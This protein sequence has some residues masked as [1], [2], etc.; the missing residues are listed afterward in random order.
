MD[1]HAPIHHAR[2]RGDG[3]WTWIWSSG[4]A[5]SSTVRERRR[6]SPTW[7]SSVT[8]WSP[9]SRR[10]SGRAHREI[11]ADGRVVTPGFVDIHTH[12]DA[13]LAWDPI[14]TSSCWH[15]VTSVV[16]G[17]C[18][19][20][21]APCR[22]EDR[23][24]LAELMESVEDIPRDAI[25]GGLPWD[26]VTYGEY[27]GSM[28]RLPKGPNVGGMVGHCAVRHH[29][30]GEREPGRHAR[31]RGR[32][33]GDG[34][35]GRRGHGRR[36]ARVL[37]LADAAPHRPRR[38]SGPRHVGHA[39]G[40]LRLRRRAR[41][42]RAGRLRDRLP[43]RRARRRGPGRHPGRDGV[44]GRGVPPLG[45]PGHLRAGPVGPPARALPPDRRLRQGAERARRVRAPADDGAGRR[46]AVRPPEPDALRPQPGLAG[47][48]RPVVAGAAVGAARRGAPLAAHRGGGGAPAPRSTST[49]CSCCPPVRPATTARRRPASPRTPSSGACRRPPRSSSW[50]WRPTARWCATSRS[51]TSASARS[52]RCWTI[53]W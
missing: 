41:P 23:S 32:H 16:M 34:A 10:L 51:S 22:P 37:D 53:P 2:Q 48:P 4:T 26:W 15:G 18:G 33:H 31:H 30:M 36:C 49:C 6:A 42:A 40:A 25:L 27:L 7:A 12:L 11:E 28:G 29:A 24:Y 50:R 1:R 52:R 14:G 38:P 13:Q 39:R 45:S 20:T 19:V 17:N 44:D 5:P 3:L 35:A 9:S 43:P 21:F 46:R 8:V 47:P